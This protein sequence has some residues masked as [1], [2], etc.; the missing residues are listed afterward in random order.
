MSNPAPQYCA[1]TAVSPS[2]LLAS[3]GWV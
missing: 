1:T 3:G 2:F